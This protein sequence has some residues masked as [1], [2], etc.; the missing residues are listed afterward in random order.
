MIP[1]IT[2][3]AE[4]IVKEPVDSNNVFMATFHSFM[5]T[6]HSILLKLYSMNKLVLLFELIIGLFIV[7]AAIVFIRN[8]YQKQKLR[9]LKAAYTKYLVNVVFFLHC[10]VF[11]VM[12]LG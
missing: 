8:R 9:Y 11:S 6:L 10:S 5:A 3:A 1:S 7:W 2:V 4:V 12:F